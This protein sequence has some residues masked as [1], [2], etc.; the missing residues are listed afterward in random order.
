M[1]IL[2]TIGDIIVIVFV[3]VL[4]FLL[5]SAGDPWEDNYYHRF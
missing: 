1:A 3:L 5:M 4:F 2:K